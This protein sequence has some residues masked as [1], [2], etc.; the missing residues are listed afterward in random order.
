[1][2]TGG[3]QGDRSWWP[4]GDSWSDGRWKAKNNDGWLSKTADDDW[5]KG[6]PCLLSVA[7]TDTKL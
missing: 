2:P 7:E 5:N 3:G 6:P 4:T 1:M